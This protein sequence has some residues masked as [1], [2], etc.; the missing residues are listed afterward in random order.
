MTLCKINGAQCVCDPSEG[1][2]CP[3]EL[4]SI[5]KSVHPEGVALLDY[6]PA[7]GVFERYPGDNGHPPGYGPRID[8]AITP[9]NLLPPAPNDDYLIRGQALEDAAAICDAAPDKI[10]Y[11]TSDEGP[12]ACYRCA[13]DIR[14]MIGKQNTSAE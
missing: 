12:A 1:V 5:S 7:Q 6:E 11:M 4:D 9:S 2:P 8:R 10:G 3:H 13:E 14:A